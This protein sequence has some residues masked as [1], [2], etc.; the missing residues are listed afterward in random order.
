[1]VLAFFL[2]ISAI[3]VASSIDSYLARHDPK[4]PII[5]LQNGK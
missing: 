2:G 5:V 3:I 4:Q 1:M